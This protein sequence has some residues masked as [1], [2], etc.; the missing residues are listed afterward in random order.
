MRV[1]GPKKPFQAVAEALLGLGLTEVY[2]ESSLSYGTYAELAQELPGV[3]LKPGKDL[4]GEL[5]MVKDAGELE[6]IRAAAAVTDAC[7]S[8]VL[9]IL[10]PGI[11]ERE[12]AVEIECFFRR[13]GAERESFETIVASGSL[14]ASP[15]ASATEKPIEAGDLVLMDF[16]AIWHGY[17]ADITRTVAV[18]RAD[19]RQREA[20][21]AVLQAQE[22]AIQAI[23]PGVKGRDVDQVARDVVADRGFGDVCYAHGLGHSLGKHVHDG[24]ALS[25]TS[26]VVLAPGM[27]ITVEPGIYD[28]EWGG[29]RIE[30]DVLVT[31]TGCELLTHSAKEF[32]VIAA[33]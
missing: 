20:Y 30:D 26:E 22:A 23:R 21:A 17:A 32:T 24:P 10:R 8:F 11:T 16:G 7:Y 6:R 2:F 4:I 5:R 19:D 12:V 27:V 28:P 14:A 18:G 15:H 25:R 33:G 29:I 9:G 3:T 1:E 31:D 13:N